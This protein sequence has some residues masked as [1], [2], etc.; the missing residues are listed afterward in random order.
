MPPP[1]HLLSPAKTLLYTPHSHRYICTPESLPESRYKSLKHMHKLVGRIIP[2]ALLGRDKLRRP[3][4]TQPP[5]C[6]ELAVDCRVLYQPTEGGIRRLCS[7]LHSTAVSFIYILIF[8]SNAYKAPFPRLTHLLSATSIFLT[9]LHLTIEQC[10]QYGA[11]NR[12]SIPH[13]KEEQ[14]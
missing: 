2:S 8:V 1:C 14:N 6:T 10:K 11:V 3:C 13:C 4:S 5:I 9:P 7:I 12:H